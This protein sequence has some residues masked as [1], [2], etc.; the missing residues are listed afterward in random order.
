MTKQQFIFEA[1]KR[2]GECWHE[3]DAENAPLCIHCE[4]HLHGYWLVTPRGERDFLIRNDE[5]PDFTTWEGFGWMLERA[6]E[7][8]WWE[9][10]CVWCGKRYF[11]LIVEFVFGQLVNPTRFMYALA[12]YLGWDSTGN[13]PK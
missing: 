3:T 4:K 11:K 9:D 10:F 5:Y 7:K 1:L 8:G 12:E 13:K 6:Q 2:E